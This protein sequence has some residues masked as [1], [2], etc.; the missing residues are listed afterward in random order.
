MRGIGSINLADAG[1]FHSSGAL[2]LSAWCKVFIERCM[3]LR[4][5]AMV[6][7]NKPVGAL[8]TG[9]NRN[10]GQEL[11]I[12]QILTAMRCF[13]LVPLG[14]RPPAFQ[15]GT[16]LS[17]KDDVSGPGTA[18]NTGLRVADFALRMAAK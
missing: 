15:T 16:L 18:R 12:Q 10:G 8:A 5:P 13:G 17:T 3:P 7:A 6:L 1:D 9:G 4:E 11:V 2:S 14:G